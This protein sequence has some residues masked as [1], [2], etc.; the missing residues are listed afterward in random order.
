M[1]V[2]R[3]VF[4]ILLAVLAAALLAFVLYA[5]LSTAGVKL[6]EGKLSLASAQVELLDC[7]GDPIDTPRG[8]VGYDEI[9]SHLPEAF[10]AVEDKRFYDH[11]G[12]D[13]LRIGKAALK[14]IAS[15]SFREGASTISQQ[16]IKNTHLTH[17]KKLS[18]KFKEWKLTLEL[19]K[20]YTKEQIMELYLNSIYFGHSAFGVESAARYYFGKNVSELVPAESALL[21]AL[22]RSPNRYSP[23]RDAEAAKKRRDFVLSLMEEQGFLSAEETA[24]AK[25]QPLP[26]SPHESKSISYV[27]LVFEELSAI[28][29]ELSSGEALRV[30]TYFSPSLQAEMEAFDSN[31]DCVL[32]AADN[33]TRALIAYRSTCGEIRRTPA[34]LIKPLAVYAPA[35]EEGFLSPATP[36][37]DEPVS[38]GNYS[39][40]NY[41]GKC[42]GYVSARDALAKSL[43]IPAVKVMNSLTPHKSSEYLRQMGLPV[44]EEDETLALALGGMRNGF[45]MQELISAYL[46]LSDGNYMPTAT[47]ARVTDGSGKV[48]YERPQERTRIL[49]EGA[50]YL[51]TDMLHTAAKE[52]TAKKL[53]SLPFY[54]SAKTGTGG[55]EQGNT[56]AYA[57]GY[58]TAHTV[59]VWLGNRDNSPIQMTGGG[60]PANELLALL[61]SLYKESSPSDPVAPKGVV[62][63]PLDME[64]YESKHRM[65]LFDPAGPAYL[66]KSELFLER[67]APQAVSEKFSKPKIETPKIYVKN[68]TVCIELA[69]TQYYDYEVTRT[70]GG[71]EKVLYRGKWR[72]L[73]C[74]GALQAGVE[75]VYTVTPYFGGKAGEKVTLPAVILEEAALPDDWWE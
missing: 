49:S 51:I 34:S 22:V 33:E 2:A 1:K 7:S 68:G 73:I 18:R 19:E 37:L 35:V 38:F 8:R 20:K 63:V 29:P 16:L 5:F 24:D 45:T 39:P 57:L 47:I 50:A 64:E 10:I 43:N 52:G 23:F 66:A 56:D 70:G 15:F 60:V 3:K 26:L 6:D 46:T 4:L 67:F 28:F 69:R 17:E 71:E 72:E 53:K 42:L 44:P 48:L 12:L 54:V 74:D 9:P 40:K 75:Y 32:M 62:E 25:S 31:C 14:N 11:G 55:T 65:V 58:T 61:K 27:S 13:I 59:G 41:D 36:L 30:E 21:A